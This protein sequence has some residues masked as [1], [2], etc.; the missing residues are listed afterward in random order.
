MA[1]PRDSFPVCLDVVIRPCCEADLPALEWFGLLSTHRPLIRRVFDQYRRGEALMLVVEANGEP[2]GQLWI[3]MDRGKQERVGEIWAVRILPCLQRLGIGA[4]LMA[5]AEALLLERGFERAELSVEIE[6]P[7]ARRFYERL[8]YDL[9]GTTT[10]ASDPLGSAQYDRRTQ[11]VLA[12][13][14]RPTAPTQTRS[15]R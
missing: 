1:E 9:T 4:R 8:G 2:S 7:A 13:T 3:E 14:L 10:T 15:A 6:N 11:W 12:K 5:A